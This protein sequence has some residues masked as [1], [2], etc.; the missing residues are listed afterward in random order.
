VKKRTRAA[1]LIGGVVTALAVASPALAAGTWTVINPPDPS[2]STFAG[3]NSVFAASPTQAW[4]VGESRVPA[5]GD[6]FN[7][8]IEE[9]NG[10]AWSIV[11]GANVGPAT[12]TTPLYGVSGSGPDDVWAVGQDSNT[13][14][15]L[16]EH[17]NGTSWSLVA[18]PA[19]EPPF[20][21]LNTVSA[22]SPTDAW[23]GGYSFPNDTITSL[24]EH[25]NGTT[26]TVVP[27]A[28]PS[29]TR[30]LSIAAVSPTDVWALGLT[31]TGP[32]RDRT[33]VMEHWNGSQWSVVT[34]PTSG[35]SL[36]SISA[37]SANDVWAVGGGVIE[38]WN[39]TQWSEVASPDGG[40]FAVHAL[41]ADDVWT[42][43]G[44]G[45]VTQQWNGTQWN[46]VP[47]AAS[48]P[49]GFVLG[50]GSIYGAESLSGVPGG[51]LFAV[52]GNSGGGNNLATILEQPQP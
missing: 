28:A 32:Q 35:P 18:S 4:A 14:T 16:I 12:S 49:T 40:G 8:L 17:W 22:D 30:I 6:N 5:S 15:S 38:Q 51:P 52:G 39:G 27:D 10:S 21:Q 37:V 1:I 9:W 11:P 20:G 23:A 26:W 3:L 46:S 36:S 19:N 7:A 42:V 2:G 48:V 33:D 47:P 41:S 24:I 31:G 43:N 44:N 13:N 25:W 45:T 34:L 50:G 29:D